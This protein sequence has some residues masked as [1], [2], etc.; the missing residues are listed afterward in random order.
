MQMNEGTSYTLKIKPPQHQF[1]EM[2][3]NLKNGCDK[4]KFIST[5]LQQIP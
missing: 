5:F 1:L 2:K 4:R 3:I